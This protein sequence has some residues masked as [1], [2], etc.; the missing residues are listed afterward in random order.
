MIKNIMVHF[1]FFTAKNKKFLF[2]EPEPYGAALFCRFRDL[3]RPEPSKKVA[4]P[5]HCL[6]NNDHLIDT[7]Y[8]PG[9]GCPLKIVI[10]F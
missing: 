4:A 5:Q 8:C 10:F 2:L 3:E 1:N 9:I 7:V 6:N